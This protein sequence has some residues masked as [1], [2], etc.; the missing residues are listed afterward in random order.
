MPE[1][2][3]LLKA[4][5]AKIIRIDGEKHILKVCAKLIKETE[6]E[7]GHSDLCGS[8]D[9]VARIFGETKKRFEGMIAL[10]VH[11]HLG[12]LL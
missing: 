5:R 11:D 3:P 1:P 12:D 8:S 2:P 10:R 4:N 6:R 7:D 9:R